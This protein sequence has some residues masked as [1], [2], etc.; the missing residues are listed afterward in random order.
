MSD[1]LITLENVSKDSIKALFDNAYF[2]TSVD[3]DGDLRVKDRV[4][5]W[6]LLNDRKDRIR[7]LAIFGFKPDTTEQQRLAFVNNVNS[8]YIIV[9]AHS[10]GN[11]TLQ[12]TYDLMINTGL[13]K[14]NLI[15][16]FKRFCEIPQEAIRDL[17]P[18]LVE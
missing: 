16:T 5:C 14:K 8:Q 11:N 1:D 10:G 18:D 3:K 17:G 7:L 2:E 13:A 9:R 15:A 6:V 12:F 4:N